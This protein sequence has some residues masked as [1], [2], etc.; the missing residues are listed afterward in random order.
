[1]KITR[2]EL[3]RA[4][5]PLKRP[6]RISLGTVE[7][8]GT[9]FVRLHGE[10][11]LY[12]M[13]EANPSL[14]ICGETV[15]TV[16]AAA[17]VYAKV[18]IGR[19][20]HDIDGATAAMRAALPGNVTARS[21]FDMALYDLLGKRAGLPL[22]AL[23]GGTRRALVTDNTIGIDTPQAMAQRAAEMRDAGFEAIKVKLGTTYQEDVARIRAI[24]D[25]VGAD[26]FLRIDANQGWDRV[27][28]LKVLADLA[29]A[30]IQYCEQPVRASDTDAL[31][32]VSRSSAIPVMADESLFDDVDALRLVRAGACRYFNIKLSKSA[33]IHTAL[34]I[35]GIAEAAGIACMVGCMIETRL[36][37]TA[38]AH[39]VS[40]R[41]NIRFAD[42]DGA[43]MLRD[44]PVTGG[45]TYGAGGA[46][47]L[48]DG[49]GLGADLRDDALAALDRTEF[50]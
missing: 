37:L 41:P 3:F 18:L 30:G 4:A 42:L 24:R 32:E 38:A 44:D 7:T 43:D 8:A 5:L 46:I 12:G 31:A 39:L 49:P 2:I 22:Y 34:R 25:A 14:P 13:G 45:M 28:A 36:G 9:V 40:A 35:N 6:F 27:T 1:M 50:A 15:G 10:D 19:P 47:T 33:G 29:D 23:L 16:T 48:P 21:A 26:T 20:A 17:E 11:G